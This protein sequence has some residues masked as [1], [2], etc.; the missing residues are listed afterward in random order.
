MK[1]IFIFGFMVTGFVLE[2]FRFLDNPSI[3]GLFLD[4]IGAY[5]LA[6]SFI[7][8]SLEDVICESWGNEGGKYPGGLSENLSISLYQ[9]GIEAKTGFMVLTIGFIFQGIGNLY[10]TF[11]VPPYIGF[12]FILLILLVI[13]I[14]HKILLKVDRISKNLEKKDIEISKKYEKLSKM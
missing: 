4:I 1:Y 13:V 3:L 14:V 5:F 8:K 12:G 7:T 11:I 6:Q 9:Q 2:Y 10:S